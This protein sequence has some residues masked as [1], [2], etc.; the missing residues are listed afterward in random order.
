MN[1]QELILKLSEMDQSKQ[2]VI[3]TPDG[4][5]V[6]DAVTYVIWVGCIVLSSNH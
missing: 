3:T 1:I 4:Y 6:I 5:L 2:V